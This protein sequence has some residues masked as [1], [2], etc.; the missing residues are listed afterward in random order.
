[1]KSDIKNKDIEAL[2]KALLKKAT[3]YETDAT[4]QELRVVSRI[5]SYITS[6]V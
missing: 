6:E 1:M 3:G 5:L 2:K 4:Q